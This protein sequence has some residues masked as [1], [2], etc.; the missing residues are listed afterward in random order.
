M[1]W[2]EFINSKYNT[3]NYFSAS[4]NY[5]KSE[6]TSGVYDDSPM[7]TASAVLLTDTIIADHT[8]YAWDE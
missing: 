8:Y 1:T 2:A 4:G 3:N 5:V 6:A 7:I